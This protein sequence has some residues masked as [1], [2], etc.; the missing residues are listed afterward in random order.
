MSE[1][2]DQGQL[3]ADSI[4][5]SLVSLLDESMEVGAIDDVGTSLVS[6]TGQARGIIEHL[7]EGKWKERLS[8]GVELLLELGPD[9]DG[10]VTPLKDLIDEVTD[11]GTLEWALNLHHQ[12]TGEG[13]RPELIAQVQA[14]MDQF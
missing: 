5:G 2:L 7:P 13:A 8:H 14:I 10:R 9:I 11:I 1:V 12:L 4:Q 3:L 6:M